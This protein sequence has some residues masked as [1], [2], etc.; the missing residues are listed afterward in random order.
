MVRGCST[1][2]SVLKGNQKERPLG[3]SSP[4]WEN[5][6]RIHLREMGWVLNS[7]DTG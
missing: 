5:N 6:I 4:R 1:H 7:T 3:R 2:E